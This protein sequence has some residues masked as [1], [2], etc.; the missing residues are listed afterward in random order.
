M[1]TDLMPK[2]VYEALRDL[3]LDG[4]ESDISPAMVQILREQ[5]YVEILDGVPTVTEPGQVV[6]RDREQEFSVLGFKPL[7]D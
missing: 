6:L 2:E 3:Y 5:G 7:A 4:S 1:S